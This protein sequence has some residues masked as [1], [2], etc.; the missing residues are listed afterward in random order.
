VQQ[1]GGA[2][3]PELGR[4]GGRCRALINTRGWDLI[5]LP[6]INDILCAAESRSFAVPRLLASGAEDKHLPHWATL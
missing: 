5:N 1:R 6:L 3:G 2:P 4:N